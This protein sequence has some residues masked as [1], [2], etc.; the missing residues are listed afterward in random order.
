MKEELK[1]IEKIGKL[2]TL[3]PQAN[4]R[5]LNYLMSLEHAKQYRSYNNNNQL[6]E[7]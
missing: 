3:E 4:L 7:E 2:L 1:L 5:V 6:G